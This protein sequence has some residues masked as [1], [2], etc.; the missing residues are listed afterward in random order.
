[1]CLAATTAAKA[2]TFA[3][4]TED[5]AAVKKNATKNTKP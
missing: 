5:K 1:M 3:K 4:A 2:S